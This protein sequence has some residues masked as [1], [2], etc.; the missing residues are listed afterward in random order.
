MK[1]PG[2]KRMKLPVVVIKKLYPDR[3]GV[4]RNV[5]VIRSG[6]GK[7][8]VNI[9]N[10]VPLELS[11]EV[12]LPHPTHQPLPDR[13]VT[14]ATPASTASGATEQRPKRAA[15]T[16]QREGLQTLLRQGRL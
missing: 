7:T 8:L 13:A 3:Q 1:V 6:R 11:T 15:A 12:A 10:L 16:Q 4:V 5:E 2:E 14:E 9:N